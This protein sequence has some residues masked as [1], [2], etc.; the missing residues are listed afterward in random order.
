ML[1]DGNYTFPTITKTATADAPIVIRAANRGK[2][3]VNS[4]VIHL[5][6]SAYVMLEGLDVTSSGA[7]I[8]FING[9]SNGMMIAFTDPSTA[10]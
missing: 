8:T 7:A 5:L 9:G 2:A 6:N 4:G 10:G 3:V 1:A